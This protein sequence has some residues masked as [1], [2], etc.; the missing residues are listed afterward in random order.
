[1]ILG[2]GFPD[3]E[4]LSVRLPPSLMKMSGGGLLVNRGGAVEELH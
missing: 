4:I 2:G 3:T 1:M